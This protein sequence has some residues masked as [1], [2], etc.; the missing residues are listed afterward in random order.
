MTIAQDPDALYDDAPI[1]QIHILVRRN[2]SMS[3]GGDIGDLNYA[4]AMLDHAKDAVRQ[5]HARMTAGIHVIIPGYDIS[6]PDERN[7]IIPA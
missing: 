2:G 7:V 6:L 4:L 1:A 5:Y 3:T